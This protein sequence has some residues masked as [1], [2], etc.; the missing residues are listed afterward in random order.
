[1]TLLEL[2]GSIRLRFF[3]DE[4]INLPLFS[5]S[6]DLT[7]GMIYWNNDNDDGKITH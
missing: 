2:R 1:M 4:A 3:C 6:S 5:P 7:L